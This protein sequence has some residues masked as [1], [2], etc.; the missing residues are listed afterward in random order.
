[1]AGGME[2]HFFGALN[3][4]TSEPEIWRKSLFLRKFRDFPGNFSL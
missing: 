4:Q 2:L 3:F 1:M